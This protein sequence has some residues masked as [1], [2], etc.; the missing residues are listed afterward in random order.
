MNE[1]P[2]WSL[3]TFL[4][5]PF[6]PGF[7][8]FA[9]LMAVGGLFLLWSAAVPAAAFVFS[10]KLAFG[11]GAFFLFLLIF[12][13]ID[14]IKE[15]EAGAK[16]RSFLIS[17]A[18]A[19]AIGNYALSENPFS[20]SLLAGWLLFYYHSFQ[21]EPLGKGPLVAR[22]TRSVALF[23][24]ALYLISLFS[25]EQHIEIFSAP[26]MLLA[27]AF[28]FSVFAWESSENSPQELASPWMAALPLAALFFQLSALI[29]LFKE[30][31]YGLLFIVGVSALYAI[32]FLVA[33]RLLIKPVP[34]GSSLQNATG[35]YILFSGVL[36]LTVAGAQIILR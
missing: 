2:Q 20:F 15:G 35:A 5:G 17:I 36:A 16:A 30:L 1:N 7:N 25:S 29:S 34:G 14:E 11:A 12:K 23:L 9:S 13:L 33:A 27:L 24:A 26:N 31:H 32:Y 10:W 22:P 21:G 8:A 18:A 6:P 28:W 19:W 3:K 4:S